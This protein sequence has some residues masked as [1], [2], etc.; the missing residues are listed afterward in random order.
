MPIYDLSYRHWPGVPGPR[1]QRWVPITW[2]GLL[3]L[4]KRRAFL[5]WMFLCWS[6][7]L[8]AGVII[9][10]RVSALQG[11]LNINAGDLFDANAW[12]FREFAKNQLFLYM[13][14]SAFAGAG[15]IANDRR[16]NALQIYL[17]KP[18]R[19]LD[20]VFGKALIV[21]AALAL[22][23]LGPSLVLY[24]LRAG[25]D[26]QG[27]YVTSH[28]MLPFQIVA[29][30]ALVIVTMSIISLTVSSLANSGRTAGVALV[31]LYVFSESIR[32]ILGLL[33]DRSYISLLS[34]VSNLKQGLDWVFGQSP[35]FD[36]H[37]AVSL[38]ALAVFLAVCAVVVYRRVR[39]VEVVT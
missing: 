30:S 35:S 7:A 39:P 12:F 20:Y 33:F 9:Y 22:V 29:A 16:T 5:F 19:P 2:A 36:I 4:L 10:L 34:P 31:M 18:L 37:P 38:V 27:G 21:A 28:L 14:T 24:L 11:D 26:R 25:L 6:P 32:G 1:S 17:S 3:P 8:V 23:T 13:L 15:L